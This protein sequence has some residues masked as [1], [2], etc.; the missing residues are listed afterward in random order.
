[1]FVCNASNLCCQCTGV[2]GVFI[3][4]A[5]R[6]AFGTFGG[7]LKDLSANKLQEVAAKAALEAG[8]VNPELVGSLV[9]G[10]VMQVGPIKCSQVCLNS[11]QNKSKYWHRICFAVAM[12]TSVFKTPSTVGH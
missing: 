4:A 3:V 1:M 9:F 12:F 6:T 8:Q 5:K 2:P 11:F 10:N 7:K